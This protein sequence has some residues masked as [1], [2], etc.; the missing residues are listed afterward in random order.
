MQSILRL[1]ACTQA[2]LLRKTTASPTVI[3]PRVFAR[4]LS[5]PIMATSNP[6]A[7]TL[8]KS[9]PDSKWKEILSA[10]EV[11]LLS[12]PTA[13]H[14]PTQYYI[15]RQKGTEPAGTGEYNKHYEQGEYVCAGCGTKLYA[16][17]TKFDSG[18][19]S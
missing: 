5:R 7:T 11:C 1:S 4:P 6:E 12:A 15:L 18:M 14:L 10:E 8:D 19:E 17:E 2:H 9:T 3:A 13:Y 16:S